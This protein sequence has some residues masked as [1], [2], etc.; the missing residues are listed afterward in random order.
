PRTTPRVR[1]GEVGVG[2]PGGAQR[3]RGRADRTG[4]PD[5]GGRRP[6]RGRDEGH[7]EGR[8]EEAARP[9]ART[10]A[11]AT[12]REARPVVAEAVHLQQGG[13]NRRTTAPAVLDYS[14]TCVRI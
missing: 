9:A 5:P 12:A 6:G 13:V 14:S 10:P 7:G 4:H 2:Q 11:A 8:E 1:R 3:R